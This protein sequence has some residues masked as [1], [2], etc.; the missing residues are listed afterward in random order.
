MT[1]RDIFRFEELTLIEILTLGA[2]SIVLA[3]VIL[4]EKDVPTTINIITE[5]QFNEYPRI[6]WKDADKNG[7]IIRIKYRVRNTETYIKVYDANGV[8]VHKQPFQ[9]SP[10]DDGTPRDFTYNWMLYYTQDYG[11]EIPPGEYEIRVCHKYDRNVD[12]ST[13]ITI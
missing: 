8:A 6:A 3:F 1:L 10:W 5:D 7:D 13:T 2:I 11:D 4:P 9:R 12:L